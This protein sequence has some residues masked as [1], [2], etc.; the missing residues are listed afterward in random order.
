MITTPLGP[1]HGHD[2][3]GEGSAIVLV[4]GLGGSIANW[5]ALAPGLT[6]IGRVTAL[7]LPGF[8][9]SPPAADWSLETQA[10]ALSSFVETQNGPAVLVGN[11]LGALLSEMVAA[12]QPELVSH[13]VLVS[14]A[15]PPR[16]PD[17]RMHWP[18]ARRLMIQATP[19]L[20][21]QAT[22]CL[23]RRYEP[24]E[25]V[26]LTLESVAHR[27]ARIPSHL[28]QSFTDLARRRR[29]M[30]WAPEAVPETGTHIAK[31][32]LRPS[33]FVAMIRKIK[34]P[35]LVVHGVEDRLV[36]PTSVEWLCSLRSD[37]KL[38]QLDDI[39]HTP[40]LE[41]V[42]RLE[43]VV[44]AWLADQMSHGRVPELA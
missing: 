9:D 26:A 39:G 40:Q 6:P 24:D 18:T 29:Q 12:S 20:G 16:L 21:K 7:D 23:L 31:L 34:A 38:I 37:W 4:H 17:P 36:S 15:T 2:Y 35:T 19:W 5:D 28:V 25:L 13:L 44:V 27:P 22:R 8:G 3:G 43:T 14:P 41:A 42:E 32:F 33:R 10:R 1:V 30:P 11:S